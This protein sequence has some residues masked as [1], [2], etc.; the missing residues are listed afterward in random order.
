MKVQVTIAMY[1][2]NSLI[3]PGDQN[4]CFEEVGV[5]EMRL[6]SA[7]RDA[8]RTTRSLH[9]RYTLCALTP[10]LLYIANLL[11][12]VDQGVAKKHRSPS[13]GSDHE[14][15]W[16]SHDMVGACMQWSIRRLA[17]SVSVRL[18]LFLKG[19]ASTMN[20]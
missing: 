6:L 10:P 5:K 14:R 17:I 2:V 11:P 8:T 7:Y 4:L 18:V 9:A 12:N 19:R 13:C 1:V 16:Y 3:R 20:S 15:T